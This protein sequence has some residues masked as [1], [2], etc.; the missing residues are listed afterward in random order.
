MSQAIKTKEIEKKAIRIK[1]G[2]NDEKALNPFFIKKRPGTAKEIVGVGVNIPERQQT[3]SQITTL[4]EKLQR[5]HHGT[6]G[7]ENRIRDF[8]RDVNELLGKA[9]QLPR[10]SSAESQD[11]KE[12]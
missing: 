10:Y 2:V 6:L 12:K 1:L 7:L 3:E 5:C 9:G 11:K 8:N 4:S